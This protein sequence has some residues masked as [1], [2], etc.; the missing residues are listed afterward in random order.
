MLSGTFPLALVSPVGMREDGFEEATLEAG[1]QLGVI[2][3][4]AL[5]EGKIWTLPGPAPGPREQQAEM[6]RKE[7][8]QGGGGGG[9][10]R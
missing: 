5:G 4:G 2:G 3:A 8:I 9:R 10:R 7:C 1:F 6:V